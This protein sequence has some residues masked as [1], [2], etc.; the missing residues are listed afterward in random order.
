[1]TKANPAWRLH[2]SGERISDPRRPYIV[3]SNHQSHADIP[4]ISH[5]PW[6]MKSLAKIEL[7]QMPVIGWMLIPVVQIINL[8]LWVLLM[9]KGYQGEMFKLPI[10]GDIAEKKA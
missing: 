8:V 1:M 5:L 3:V 10:V 6:E 7:F 9:V 2:I 4:L